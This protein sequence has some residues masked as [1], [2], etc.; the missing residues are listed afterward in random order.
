MAHHLPRKA[1]ERIIGVLANEPAVQ[2]VWLFGSRALDRAREGSDID[3]C[4]DGEGLD[5]DRLLALERHLDALDLPWKVDLVARRQID[6]PRLV[7][8]IRRV[9]RIWFE[10]PPGGQGQAC[11]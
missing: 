8:H 6:N 11:G 2:R 1:I 5:S 7:D 3:L 4:L 10:R 9:G